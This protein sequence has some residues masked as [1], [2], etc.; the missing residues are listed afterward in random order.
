MN[1]LSKSDTK[2]NDKT[3]PVRHNGR[4][5]MQQASFMLG[6]MKPDMAANAASRYSKD[7]ADNAK[8]RDFWAE[9]GTVIG[10]A[11][12]SP[13]TLA[14]VHKAAA[15]DARAAAKPKK[16]QKPRPVTKAAP[17]APAKPKAAPDARDA[18]TAQPLTP[19]SNGA[20]TFEYDLRKANPVLHLFY[21]KEAVKHLQAM[22]KIERMLES[23]HNGNLLN[24]QIAVDNERKR[25]V[26]INAAYADAQ[27]IIDSIKL[28][29]G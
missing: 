6:R 3:K 28:V 18:A 5:I 10:H 17:K 13:Q 4:T 12:Q 1:N 19:A 25:L 15:D 8:L 29:K 20:P 22:N 23:F 9:V 7:A 24:L 16:A 26:S 11:G 27:E 14:G 21:M 2:N